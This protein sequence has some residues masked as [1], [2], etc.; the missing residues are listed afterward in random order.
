M[1]DTVNPSL[2]NTNFTPTSELQVAYKDLREYLMLR[3]SEELLGGG[4]SSTTST[5]QQN[6][7]RS[8]RTLGMATILSPDGAFFTKDVPD[9]LKQLNLQPASQ[10]GEKETG[11]INVY[12]AGNTDYGK[13]LFDAVGINVNKFQV[14]SSSV[15]AG[16]SVVNVDTATRISEL[17][18]KI[19]EARAS[20]DKLLKTKP[21]PADFAKKSADLKSEVRILSTQRA[22]LSVALSEGRRRFAALEGANDKRKA[23]LLSSINRDE[24]T[25]SFNDAHVSLYRHVAQYLDPASAASEYCNVFFNAI[26]SINMSMCVPFFR[27]NIIDRFAKKKGRHSKLSLSAFLKQSTDSTG[28]KIF[29]EA[30]PFT[31]NTSVSTAKKLR[32]GKVIS[33]EAFFAPQT[34]LPDPTEILSNPRRLDTSVPLLSL[35]SFSIGIETVGIALLSKKTADLSITLHDRSRLTDISP[36]VSVGNFSS[37]YFEIEWGWTHPHGEAKFD[38]PVARYLNSLRYR[39]V[40]SPT[41]YNMTMA[42]GGAMNINIRLI[43]GGS[44][45]AVNGSILNGGFLTRTYASQ[46]L[47]KLIKS[48]ITAA[49]GEE[50]AAEEIRTVTKVLIDKS[51]T[52]HMVDGSFVKSLWAYVDGDNRTADSRSKIITQLQEIL[53]QS[54]YYKNEELFGIIRNNIPL[55]TSYP[56]AGNRFDKLK[57][58]YGSQVDPKDFTSVSSCLALLVGM[59]LASTGLYSEVQLHTFKFNDAAGAMAGKQI[60]D[61]PIRFADVFKNPD[62]DGSLA[63]NTSISNALSL[64]ANY[65]SNPKQP[66][67]EISSPTQYSEIKVDES[68]KENADPVAAV[69]TKAKNKADDFKKPDDFTTPNIRYI[70]RSIPAKEYPDE[71]KKSIAD[72]VVN[73][74]KLIAQIIIY[75]A[76]ASPNY[77]KI[78]GA[79]SYGKLAGENGKKIK[80]DFAKD[81]FKRAFPSIIYGAT[82]SMLKSVNVSTDINNAISQ[83][84]ILDIGKDFYLGRSKSDASTDVSEIS[85]F[86]GAVT[87][88]MI[89]LPII[90][91]GQEVYLDLG[92]GTTLDALYYVTAVK[93]DFRPGEF[94]TSLTLTYKGQGSVMSLTTMLEKFNDTLKPGEKAPAV[95]KDATSAPTTTSDLPPFGRQTGVVRTVSIT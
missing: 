69:D 77:D 9:V 30:E 89:G 18:M 27:L 67:Y 36:L 4:N 62:Q 6:D 82:N 41:S 55:V 93:H 80:P 49:E 66:L 3:N 95:V 50:A 40:F 81:V 91:R 33:T 68:K 85:L 73:P 71:N 25:P 39:E 57:S 20:F 16:V 78:I 14:N 79:Y 61:A 94:T 21:R 87:I 51:R 8:N 29:Y 92:T 59:P 7:S 44:L 32:S 88:S 12:G 5:T 83:Q 74:E 26:D 19:T 47:D 86:P 65:L 58:S 1:G 31:T 11:D 10:T 42:D 45:D 2:N 84:N 34:L 64:L 13:K 63:Q 28:D 70:I 52:A 37:L 43:G 38:N 24:N 22:E 46:M 48:E 23:V 60:A 90:E 15:A 76:N 54:D 53:E 72:Y 35:N 17:D 75:D 56:P